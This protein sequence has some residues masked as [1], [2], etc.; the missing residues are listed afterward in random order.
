MR[1][2]AREPAAFDPDP[3][4]IAGA[5][6]RRGAGRGV[7]GLGAHHLSRHR[8]AQRR[9]HSGLWRPRAG[10]RLPAARRLPDPADRPR[11]RRGRGDADDRPARRRRPRSGSA[12]RRRGRGASC[13]PPAGRRQ[14][15]GAGGWRR[16]SMSIRSTG[17]GPTSRCRIC[18]RSPAPCSTS[19][20]RDALRELDRGAR[21]G[22]RAARPRPESRR[23]VSSSRAAQARSATSGSPTSI[24]QRSGRG[25]SSGPQDFDLPAWW[26][27]SLERF[28][29]ELRPGRRRACAPRRRG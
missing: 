2:Y 26:R 9:R 6:D 7:R 28:E 8:R 5:A 23:L 3:A 21:L 24:D 18:R 4:A 10:R 20:G 22:G 16:A 25:A 27:A 17:T 11:R 13:S 19:G 1:K 14:R 15:R 29:A 12:P